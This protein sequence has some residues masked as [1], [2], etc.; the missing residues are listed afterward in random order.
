MGKKKKN[1]Q[2]N[3]AGAPP[4]TVIYHGEEQT[5]KVK[6]TL[7]EYNETEFVEKDFFD[8][9]Q[10]LNSVNGHL[11]KW[12]NVDG[13]HQ[14]E[15]IEA[16]GKRFNIHPLTLEDIV[17]TNQRAKFEDYENYVVSIMKMI[18][19]HNNELRSE[20]LSV[21]LMEGLV[22]SFQ[23][24]NGGD[25]FD[26]IRTRIR[27][28]KGRIRKM[29]AD[30]L[31]YALLDAV[32]DC[33]FN[34]LE[35][36]GDKIEVLEEELIVEP[37]KSTIE[38]LHYMKREMIFVRKAVWPVRELINNMQRSES[39]LI[40]PTTDIYLRDVHDHTVRVID[41][42]ETY[43]DLLSGMMDIYL[44]SVSN[45]MNEVMKILTIITTIFVPVTFIAG[46]YG[47]NFDYMPELHTKWGYPAVWALMLLIIFSLIIY[48]KRK[49]WL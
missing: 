7:I 29:G 40:K 41:T 46:V 18:D 4:G 39:E 27:Q 24:P 11:V 36:I 5:E 3:R 31:A 2:H 42:V 14:T 25:A 19:Y 30:Y 23:E 16:I 26:L 47:M 32:V 43:R 17:N 15:L 44:S 9:S 38:Q 21:I 13:V 8:L 34:I 48:F 6:I 45:K 49:K 12:I 20:Q 22:I 10:C 35:K 1:K 37:R 33:Y 28:A